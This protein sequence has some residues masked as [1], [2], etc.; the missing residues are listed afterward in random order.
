MNTKA[1]TLSSLHS[2]DQRP[3]SPDPILPPALFT[4]LIQWAMDERISIAIRE[5]PAPLGGPEGHTYV[6]STL[7]LSLMD[8]VY[9]SQ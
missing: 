1:D 4:C 9:S 7:L 2:L 6:P 5:E 3:P 8:C